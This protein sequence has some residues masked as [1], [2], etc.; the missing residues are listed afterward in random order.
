MV[1]HVKEIVAMLYGTSAASPLSAAHESAKACGN[2][3]AAAALQ[4]SVTPRS[5]WHPHPSCVQNALH[6]TTYTNKQP[7]KALLLPPIAATS[8]LP[9]YHKYSDNAPAGCTTTAAIA[10]ATATAAA[11][12]AAAAVATPAPR[13]APAGTHSLVKHSKKE[14]F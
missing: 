7:V 6:T 10:T 4:A 12:A 1:T 2:R 13:R 5:S 14:S 9:T 3:A 11:A 8:S